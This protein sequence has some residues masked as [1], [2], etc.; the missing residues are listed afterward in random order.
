V[1][2]DIH[3]CQQEL[4]TSTRT[5]FWDCGFHSAGHA[6]WNSL[7]HELHRITDNAL[8]KRHLKTLL[9]SR[10]HVYCH[11]LTL[12]PFLDGFVNG[13]IQIYYHYYQSK[14]SSRAAYILYPACIVSWS[15]TV[16]CCCRLHVRSHL[17]D[18]TCSSRADS[19]VLSFVAADSHAVLMHAVARPLSVSIT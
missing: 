1:T 4:S 12:L 5:K 6:A 18:T 17:Q 2:C 9:F 14:T 15:P 3:T 7:P 16:K 8:F 19:P 11:S 10:I 13:T